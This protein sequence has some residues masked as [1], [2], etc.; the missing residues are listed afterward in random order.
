MISDLFD[1]RP[2]PD[3]ERDHRD[4]VR[5]IRETLDELRAQYCGLFS[6]M[7]VASPEEAVGAS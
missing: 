6:E 4:A 7:S 5:T 1:D 3:T 2:W